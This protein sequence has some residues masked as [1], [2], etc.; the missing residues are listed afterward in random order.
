MT[1]TSPNCRLLFQLWQELADIMVG[2][3]AKG[4]SYGL[5]V[6]HQIVNATLLG[7]AAAKVCVGSHLNFGTKNL[8]I[9]PLLFYFFHIFTNVT[10]NYTR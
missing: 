3:N 9:V 10:S 4:P 1:T 2:W 5:S 8:K 7:L 6:Q